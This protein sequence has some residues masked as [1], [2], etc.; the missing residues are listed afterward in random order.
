MALTISA[1]TSQV[2]LLLT[3]TSTEVASTA[4]A[5]T[6]T[7]MTKLMLM[8]LLDTQLVILSATVQVVMATV[9]DMVKAS[10]ATDMEMEGTF[11]K[12]STESLVTSP[13]T[14]TQFKN[15]TRPHL[16]LH[17]LPSALTVSRN[18]DHSLIPTM[19]STTP[20]LA[21]NMRDSTL[22]ILT[23]DTTL[24][25]SI[26]LPRLHHFLITLLMSVT[27]TLLPTQRLM[28]LP[29]LSTVTT[30]TEFTLTIN[31]TNTRDPTTILLMV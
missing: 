7:A 29:Q 6:H 16:T 15:T 14:I 24:L 11:R 22:K 12:T 2:V 17:L 10:T 8:E 30:L 1:E 9:P 13:M 3:H 21:P 5:T 20:T 23:T 19:D 27:M 28:V 25:S 26:L 18:L 4:M 31:I